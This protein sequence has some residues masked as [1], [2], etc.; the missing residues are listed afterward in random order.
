L[1]GKFKNKLPE[2]KY[3]ADVIGKAFSQERL[4]GICLLNFCAQG[5]TLLCPEIVPILKSI[6]EQGHYIMVV[7]NGT[8]TKQIEEIIQLP[9]ELLHKLLIKF[10]F[11]F[12]ELKRLNILEKWFETIKRVKQSGCSISVE[13]TPNDELIPYIDE[14]KRV[15]LEHLGAL[16]H[17]TVARDSTKKNLPILTKLSKDNYRKTWEVFDSP[18]FDF[19]MTTFNIK[20]KEF[21]YAGEW[22][23]FINIGTGEFSQCYH[24]SYSQNI[25]NNPDNP[26]KFTPIGH[27]CLQPHCHNSHSLLTLGLIPELNTPTYSAIRNRRCIDGSYWLT[28]AMDSFLSRKLYESNI[29]VSSEKQKEVDFV[30]KRNRIHYIIKKIFIKVRNKF[31]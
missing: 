5:E 3:T 8:T 18:M 10:S 29:L 7:T 27:N 25:F 2:F 13:L 26:I 9:E 24:T 20:R 11:H 16:C 12:L 23:G 22:F 14:I 21:C 6:L 28:S 17:I 1:T 15:C 30:W 19:K 31:F 4:G